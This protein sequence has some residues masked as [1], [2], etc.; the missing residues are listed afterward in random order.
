MW[1]DDGS[2]RL[3]RACPG[4]GISLVGTLARRLQGGEGL[5]VARGTAFGQCEEIG[6]GEVVL[7][8]EGLERV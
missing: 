6:R 1:W 5:V 3:A 4:W 2:L 7:M 8:N